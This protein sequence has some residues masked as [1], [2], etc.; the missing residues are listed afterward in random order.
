MTAFSLNNNDLSLKAK[1]MFP[2]LELFVTIVRY[3]FFFVFHCIAVLL[4]NNHFAHTA[5]SVYRCFSN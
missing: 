5:A 1:E 2:T 3:S 4:Y